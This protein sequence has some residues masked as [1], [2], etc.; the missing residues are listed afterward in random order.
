[1]EGSPIYTELNVSP[2]ILSIL[3][4]LKYQKKYKIEY[5]TIGIFISIK[6]FCILHIEIQYDICV[7]YL[8]F[9]RILEKISDR[10]RRR[11]A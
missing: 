2:R 9:V 5:F 4:M 3:P 1:M 6:S 8:N 11:K 7:E 10:I